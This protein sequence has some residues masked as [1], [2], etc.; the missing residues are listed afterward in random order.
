MDYTASVL[1][2][3]RLDSLSD[4]A[5]N[6]Y[7]CSSPS[8]RG[9][10]G[11]L[12]GL[13][14]LN[15]HSRA[16]V[17]HSECM[18]ERSLWCTCVVS[19]AALGLWFLFYWQATLRVDLLRDLMVA[20]YKSDPRIQGFLDPLTYHS[21]LSWNGGK[22]W[23]RHVLLGDDDVKLPL[24]KVVKNCKLCQIIIFWW[25]LFAYM[26]CWLWL[27]KIHVHHQHYQI[28]TKGGRWTVTMIK[29]KCC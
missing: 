12:W 14:M 27:V 6:T 19:S 15:F 8:L 11:S 16:V 7:Y 21:L 28:V 25:L 1:I 4:K 26:E 24:E 17:R 13:Q 3:W 18:R 10:T 2:F 9:I 22:T 20:K 29:A 23:G 5:K